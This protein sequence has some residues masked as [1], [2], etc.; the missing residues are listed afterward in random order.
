MRPWARLHGGVRRGAPCR[1]IFG[2]GWGNP[3]GA[4]NGFLEKPDISPVWRRREKTLAG[5]LLAFCANGHHVVHAV[6]LSIA[7][8]LA[9]GPYATLLCRAWCD[10]QADAA[11]GCQHVEP[12]GSTSVAGADGC[13]QVMLNVAAFL[14]EEIRRG[15]PA[16]DAAHAALVPR[17]LLAHSTAYARPGH[18]PGR[19]W[20]PKK[21]PLLTARRI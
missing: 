6:V 7:L 12:T 8:T 19:G 5:A 20:S 4:D 17:Y 18:E 9:V 1:G 14:R 11:T 10:P 21:R 16:P 2:N 15:G 3:A 13:D